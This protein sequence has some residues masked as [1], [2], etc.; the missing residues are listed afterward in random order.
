MDASRSGF[1]GFAR[2]AIQ[3]LADLALPVFRYLAALR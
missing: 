3:L 2:E 1:A